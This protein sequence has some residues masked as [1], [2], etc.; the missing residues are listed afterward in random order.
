MTSEARLALLVWLAQGCSGSVHDRS[1]GDEPLLVIHGHVE[2][3]ALERTHPAA[4]LL[5]VLAWAAVPVVNPICLE[6]DAPELRGACPDPHGVFLRQI[7]AAAPVDADG[8]FALPLFAL[9]GAGASVGD[10][11]TRITYGS[12]L[13]LEDVDGD[14]V[15][16]LPG[17][18]GGL[19]SGMSTTTD[20]VVAA[21]FHTLRAGQARVVLREGGFVA[22]SFFYPAPGCAAPPAGFSL[23]LVPPYPEDGA[24]PAGCVTRAL[25]SPVEV[26]AL[27]AAQAQALGC[28][29]WN[30]GIL[31]EDAPPGVVSFGVHRARADDPAPR[32]GEPVCL[33]R[34]LLAAVVPD[35]CPVLVVFALKGCG[36]DPLCAQPEWDDSGSPPAWWPCH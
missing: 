4:P 15:A 1:V 25:D 31:R 5:G 29:G 28:R 9:P 24:A 33:N 22:G 35:I 6:F 36:F 32:V 8:N 3:A 17:S 23:W 30:P 18:S 26:A 34:T 11:V 20:T 13:V 21:T 2:V 12:L 10:E 7:Q 14:G 19:K 27:P 16:T